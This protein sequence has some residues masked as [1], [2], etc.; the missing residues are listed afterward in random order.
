MLVVGEGEVVD[1]LRQLLGTAK[2]RAGQRLSGEDA[3][4][5]LDLLS[6]L[7]EVGVKWK[8]TLGCAASQVSFFL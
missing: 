2:A 4:P 5:D 8:V 1:R 3:E 6:E 7:A